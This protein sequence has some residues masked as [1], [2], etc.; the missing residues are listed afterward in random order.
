MQQKK[1]TQRLVTR[2]SKRSSSSD[3]LFLCAHVLAAPAATA[4]HLRVLLA[5]FDAVAGDDG[6]LGIVQQLLVC[7]TRPRSW[8][9]DIVVLTKDSSAVLMKMSY[10]LSIR[11]TPAP[12]LWRSLPP[13]PRVAGYFKC[14]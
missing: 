3:G 8:H 13:P 14:V 7:D 2:H 10:R 6:P 12:S 11:G 1:S 5:A 9:G 4:A